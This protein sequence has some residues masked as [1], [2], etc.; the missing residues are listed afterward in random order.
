[1]KKILSFVKQRWVVSLLGLL[2]V[3]LL[4]WFVGPYFAFAGVAPLASAVVRLIVILVLVLL[5]GANNLRKQLKAKKADDEIAEGIVSHDAPPDPDQSREEI[6]TLRR[7]FEEAVEVLRKSRKGRALSLYDLPWYIIIGPPGSGKTT[8]LVNSGL[9]F[10]LEQRFGKEA[11][12]GVGGTRNCDWWFT[13]EAVLLDTAGRYVTQDSDQQTDSKAWE[14][15]IDLL[16]KYR[17]RRPVNG[18][19]VAISVQDLLTQ[20]DNERHRQVLAIRKRVDELHKQLG[21]RF[22]VY[23]VLTKCDLIAGFMEFFDDLG[24]EEREQVWGFTLPLD[25][26]GSADIGEQAKREFT[27]LERR[28]NDSLIDRLNQERDVRR[29][30]LI[31]GFPA[32]F[33]AI[34]DIVSRFLQDTFQANRYEQPVMLRGLYMTSG[35]QEGAPIDRL[36]GAMASSF[37]LD[38]QQAVA[39]YGSSGRS[40]FI[41]RFLKEV[42]FSEAGLA[43]VNRRVALRR[44]LFQNGAYLAAVAILVLALA[45][46][47]VS[48]SRNKTYVAEV[49][50]A[51]AGYEQ[52]SSS[53]LPEA[54]GFDDI[55]PQLDAMRHTVEVANQ[56]ENDIPVTMRW[57]LYQGDAL[58]EGANDAYQREL[59]ALLLRPVAA[60][61][62]RRLRRSAGNMQRL[63]ESLRFYLMLGLPEHLNADELS[64]LVNR[65]FNDAFAGDPE[66]IERLQGH[67]D[68]LIAAGVQPIPLDEDLIYRARLT[69]SRASPAELAYGR[70]KLD[71]AG[72][73][74]NEIRL[75]EAAGLGAEEA[76]ERISGQPLGSPISSLFTR[77][78]Y[79]SV[80]LEGGGNIIS[81]LSQERWVLGDQNAFSAQQ[82]AQLVD[83]LIDLYERD[84]IA[85]WDATLKDIRL[86]E[87]RDRV[88]AVDVLRMLSGPTSPMRN[89]LRTVEENTNL[90]RVPAGA[91]A[92][93]EVAGDAAERA[94]RARAGRAAR[95]FDEAD[96][97]GVGASLPQLPGARV[98]RHFQDINAVVVSPSGAPP[99][100]DGIIELLDRMYRQLDS[101]GV[102]LGD[103]DPLGALASSGGA[104]VMDQV[105][106]TADRQPEPLRRWLQQLSAGG[107]GATLAGARQKLNENWNREVK[108]ECQLLTGR[109]PFVPNSDQDVPLADFARLFGYGG[110][111]DRFFE[112]H[113]AALV[114]TSTSPWR[115]RTQDGASLGMDGRQLAVFERAKRIREM[116]FQR[117]GQGPAVSFVLVPRTLDTDVDRFILDIDGQSFV[118]EHGPERD[119][120]VKWPG[121]GYGK[122]SYVFEESGG[123]RPNRAAEGPWA[124]F[125][126]LDGARV[127]RQSEVDFQVTFEAGGRQARFRLAA[128]SVRNPFT[129]TALQEFRCPAG[130]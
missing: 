26:D 87:L 30:A 95:L 36:M 8:A 43:G 33:S 6:E 64:Y 44:A 41:S 60:G 121:G 72:D 12:R 83:E 13:N 124:W 29:R 109:Y 112:E 32:Q 54:S 105:R 76:F 115:W 127:E 16:K 3:A 68:A 104:D 93:A 49:N 38:R 80:A 117:G 45:A 81:E 34:K 111:L 9:E 99:A 118:Y 96:R 59:N 94:A 114:N 10:P 102:D 57:W 130:F 84:Y 63:Y 48:H 101:I 129:Q 47:T 82:R 116:F 4:I 24:H 42:A 31:H 75:D 120:Q 97:A 19:F 51:L 58:G 119:W 85:T 23:A 126:I 39:A 88:H 28:L 21:I 37:G 50:E 15:F 65:D 69:L 2:L 103:S 125:R 62:E 61:L 108:S 107:R 20:S 56:H 86:V 77:S 18:V 55:L 128:S 89:L 113:L 35:T 79:M 70:L 98:A 100:I 52:V 53:G 27:M 123:G 22:P 78:A 25:E 40:Y 5:W 67:F 17:G 14:G 73:R 66:K 11:V 1:M 106:R 122:A 110:S 71:Y 46:W 92:A 7:R 74:A 91:C 90:T